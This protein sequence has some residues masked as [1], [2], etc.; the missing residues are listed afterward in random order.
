MEEMT[1]QV[2][3]H[4]RNLIYKVDCYSLLVRS[5]IK[6]NK[7]DDAMEVASGIL[8]QLEGRNILQYTKDLIFSEVLTMQ[9]SMKGKSN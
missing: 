9:S 5:L 4:R 1:D 8:I 7:K 3:S 2:L 6:R